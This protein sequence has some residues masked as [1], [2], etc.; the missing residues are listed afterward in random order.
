MPLARPWCRRTVAGV[1][2]SPSPFADVT[3]VVPTRNESACIDE[4]LVR[5]ARLRPAAVVVVDDSDDDT[6]QR[7]LR[8]ETA[9]L[10]HRPTAGRLDGLG[11]A[12]WAAIDLVR[13][14]WMLVMDGDGQ[15]NIERAAELV[16][17][18]E[19]VDVIIASRYRTPEFTTGTDAGVDD[20]M[21]RGLSLP[22]L[23][24]SRAG[25]F[26]ATGLHRDRLGTISDP[27]SGFFL[28]RVDAVRTLR[29]RPDGFKILL[30]ILLSSPCPLV[31]REVAIPLEPR[32]GGQSKAGLREI[33]RLTRLLLRRRARSV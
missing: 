14:P 16:A 20:N 4:T 9:T 10:L 27:L 30:D 5:I 26:L 6:P 23:L 12:V 19:G 22:R 13:T 21:N 28:V 18:R 1:P 15:H 24:F 31:V 29:L 32:R 8:H 33:I 2:P 11:G 7:I 3:V 25:T 17:G